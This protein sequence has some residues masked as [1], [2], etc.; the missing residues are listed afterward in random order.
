MKEFSK[1]LRTHISFLAW[2]KPRVVLY[3]LSIIVS[4]TMFS[5]T[6]FFYRRFVD[7]VPT[8]DYRALFVTLV[9]FVVIRFLSSVL[10]G[11]AYLFGDFNI[12]PALVSVRTK[13]VKHI[14]DLDFAFHTTKSTGSL[15]SAIKRGDGAFWSLTHGIHKIIDVSVSFV[16]MA[17][18][19]SNL[20]L[21]F[22]IIIL[23]SFLLTVL[24]ARFLVGYNI[25]TR[26]NFNTEEDNVSSVIVDN[27]INF[28]TV[29]LFAKEDWERKR[30]HEY[31]KP[32]QKRLWSHSYSWR[33]LDV[34]L[35]TIISISIFTILGLG[36]QL[37]K[38]GAF[39]LGDFVLL[40]GFVTVFFPQLWELMM[41]F[42]DI[43]K[44]YEDITRYYGLLDNLIEIKDPEK[45]QKLK[46]PKGEI[47]LDRVSFSYHE[48][49]KNAVKNIS[50]SIREGQSVALVGRSGS[51]KTTL[52]KLLM[53][54]YD[55]D[56]GDIT[57]DG[58]NIKS[59]TKSYL[60]SL[61]GV[62]P[63]EPVMFNNTIAYN[64]GYGDPNAS[65]KEI[66]AA[67]KLANLHKF[68][69]SLPKEYETNVGERGIKLSGG[70]KQRLAIARMILSNPRIIIFDEATSQLDSENEK[71][72]QD[73]FWKVSANKTTIIIAHRLSTA[74]RADKIVVMNHGKIVEEGSHTS[75]LTN[76]N[77]IYKK[78]WDL[79]TRVE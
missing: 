38:T 13:V 32:W 14:Q 37:T 55:V 74:M 3:L 26:R 4:S 71:K 22:L 46:N 12:I 6:P 48:G 33:V 9:G 18:V 20:D 25:K 60:R 54:F 47:N 53:R 78:F 49:K 79:Q 19:F 66:M 36:L 27:I 15:I 52:T 61:M 68:V 73:A 24:S 1:I 67:A 51:G 5:V 70:Q 11:L 72:I 45:S 40:L 30:L 62:V 35:A 8:G 41:G 16:I 65:K 63:Q 57:I 7:L 44:S 10:G 42:R 64:I 75:L 77:S 69:M 23:V 39:S 28:E 34:T 76:D 58:V 59:F 50:L 29:K 17:Y 21:R 56:K 43:A 31:F 2:S